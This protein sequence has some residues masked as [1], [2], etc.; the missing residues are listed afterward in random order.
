MVAT[1]VFIDE[2][3]LVCL[4]RFTSFDSVGMLDSSS[5]SPVYT[6]LNSMSLSGTLEK[7]EGPGNK[8]PLSSGVRMSGGGIELFHLPYSPAQSGNASGI[9]AASTQDMSFGG[10]M[11][12]PFSADFK[13]FI[14]MWAFGTGMRSY[15]IQGRTGVTPSRYWKIQVGTTNGDTTVGIS[16]PFTAAENT[17]EHVVCTIDSAT[18]SDNIRIYISGILV[19]SGSTTFSPGVSG[20]HPPLRLGGT[21]AS[22]SEQL[23]NSLA[24]AGGQLAEVFMIRRILSSG[25]VAGVYE[26]GFISRPIAGSGFSNS[27]ELDTLK[28]TIGPQS[29]S[30][31]TI[32]MTAWNA[33]ESADPSGIRHMTSGYHPAWIKMLDTG[34]TSGL[35]FGSINQNTISGIK[36]ITFRNSTPETTLNNIKFWLSNESAFVGINGWEVAQH[37][38]SEWLPNLVLSSGSGLVG[39]SLAVASSVLQS[40]GSTTISGATLN[41]VSISG[42]SGVSQYI[43]VSFE[44]NNDFTAGTYGPTGFTFRIT[45]DNI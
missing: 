23:A 19:T 31:S 11:L 42:E 40:D 15:V 9:S 32:V 33:N 37:I 4:Y 18:T 24:S 1:N 2:V 12:S 45:A 10:W 43:Y 25:E 30:A 27:D 14:G 6:G 5:E 38:D 17:Y 35:N 7:V 41:G 36:A 13:D 39:R 16:S 22:T 29:T 44:T 21:S 28:D 3:D 34:S 8:A 20:A 26:S